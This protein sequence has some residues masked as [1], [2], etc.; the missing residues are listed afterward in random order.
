MDALTEAAL[1]QQGQESEQKIDAGTASDAAASRKK[2]LSK[3]EVGERALQAAV[4]AVAACKEKVAAVTLKGS[5]ATHNDKKMQQRALSKL[6]GLEQ[7]VLDAQR[8][9]DQRRLKAEA[10]A[11]AAA[12]KTKAAAERE[13]F[14]RAFS[15]AGLMFMV[16]TR[17]RLQHRMDNSS[18]KTE[19]VWKRVVHAVSMAASKGDLPATDVR[20]EKATEKRYQLE[21]GE[22][23]LWCARAQRAVN[24]SGVRADE[25]EDQV[26]EHYRPTTPLFLK[27]NMGMRPMAQPPLQMS[28]ESADIGGLPPSAMPGMG[29]DPSQPAAAPALPSPIHLPYDNGGWEEDED[30]AEAWRRTTPDDPP[31]DDGRILTTSPPL[32]PAS[33]QHGSSYAP[34]SS[35]ATPSHHSSSSISPPLH[36][37]GESS[38]SGGRSKRQKV[39]ALVQHIARESAANRQ[40]LAELAERQEQVCYSPSVTTVVRTIPHLLPTLH[41]GSR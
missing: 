40:F 25:V 27:Y 7:K 15:D 13:E 22:F 12:A 19:Q 33:S 32:L 38:S 20:S 26:K 18:D 2:Q 1:Q 30:F 16:E 28:G 8:D 23:K 29:S 35:T 10:D 41:A 5:M 11:A 39:D 4:A 6:E 9:L 37:G 17:L 14:N 36:I 34:S 31:P 24:L 21:Y 3:V